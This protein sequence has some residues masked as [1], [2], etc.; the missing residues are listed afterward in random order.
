MVEINLAFVKN[1]ITFPAYVVD[2]DLLGTSVLLLGTDVLGK[3]LGLNIPVRGT[4]TVLV[5]IDGVQQ[6]IG[7]ITP[8]L[9]CTSKQPSQEDCLENLLE[10]CESHS[11]MLGRV[12]ENSSVL[13]V[14]KLSRQS[15]EVDCSEK[16]KKPLNSSGS[17]IFEVGHC[18][19]TLLM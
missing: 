7:T 2:S 16:Q 13:T 3:K 17:A 15:A 6:T 9:G 10:S 12:T 19:K 8:S 14:S 4:P 11:G 18:Q 1:S 5:D